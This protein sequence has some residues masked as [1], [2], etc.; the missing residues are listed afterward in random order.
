MIYLGAD[1]GG[2]KFKE[3]IKKL[4]DS[5]NVKYKDLGNKKLDPSDDFPDYATE[6]AKKVVET[7]ERGILICTTGIGMCL[8]A[9]KTKGA[10]AVTATSKKIA[11]QSREHLNSNILCLGANTISFKNAKKIIKEWLNAEFLNAKEKYTRRLKK[12]E[13]IENQWK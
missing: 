2:Y 4:L 5:M 10:R 8:A 9:N 12:I 13:K 11:R 1:H 3:K 6:V 7:G